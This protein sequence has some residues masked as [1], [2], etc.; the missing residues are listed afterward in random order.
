[1]RG[2]EPEISSVELAE[3]KVLAELFRSLPELPP[4][5]RERAKRHRSALHLREMRLVQI[6][7]SGQMF[8][9]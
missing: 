2:S 8:R 1:M 7:K 9:R 5:P 3:D 4:D 6:K